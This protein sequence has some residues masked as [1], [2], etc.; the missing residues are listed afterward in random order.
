MA[1]VVEYIDWPI[2]LCLM[3]MSAIGHPI[4]LSSKGGPK[5]F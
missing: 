5:R 4:L 3:P 1:A 2:I